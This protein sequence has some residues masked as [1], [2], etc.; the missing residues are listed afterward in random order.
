MRRLTRLSLCIYPLLYT[1]LCPSL[2]VSFGC[3]E[4]PQRSQQDQPII[5]GGL[6]TSAPQELDLSLFEGEETRDAESIIADSS[7]ADMEIIA[8]LEIIADI[9]LQDLSLSPDM[10]SLDHSLP[11]DPCVEGYEQGEQ[12]RC[13]DIDEC[14]L[15][16]QDQS[17]LC[18]ESDCINHNGGYHCFSDLDEDGVD[19]W[20]DNC[21][22]VI[23]P[24][25]GDLDRDGE[26][27]LCDA[28]RDGDLSYGDSDC[29]DLD[30]SLGARLEDAECDGALDRLSVRSHLSV[31]WRHSCAI[32]DDG[33]LTCWGGSP[34]IQEQEMN[35]YPALQVPTDLEGELIYDW[36]NLSAG[37]AYTCGIRLGGILT[38]WGD[39]RHQ[40]S[41]PPVN[42]NG[43][44]YRD[45]VKVSTGGASESFTC[46]LHADG[47]I[48]CWGADQHEQLTPPTDN[49]GGE[50]LELWVDLSSGYQ[51]SCG[52]LADGAIRCWGSD[53]FGQSTPPTENELGS[54]INEGAEG[55]EGPWVAVGAGYAHSCGLRA[56]GSIYC[57]GINSDQQSTPTNW[58]ELGNPRFWQGISVGGFHGCGIDAHRSAHCW[59]SNYTGQSRLPIE[60]FGDPYQDWVEVVA[61]RYHSC[62]IRESGEVTCWGWNDLGQSTPPADLRARKPPRQDNCRDLF[63]PSQS[64]MDNDGLGD[65]CDSD[66]DGDGL[67]S[68]IEEMWG[69]DPMNADSDSD[70]LSDGVE[71]GCDQ[72]ENDTWNCPDDAR[73]SSPNQAIDALAADSDQDQILDRDDNCPVID[74]FNQA[75]LDGDDLGDVCDQD[76]D[77]DGALDSEDCLPRDPTLSWRS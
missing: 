69:L 49:E 65:S 7:L 58:D 27:D 33:S 17:P 63:N 77:G 36:I 46:G 26:G 44:P 18:P 15:A 73:Q 41:S 66:P 10:E 72:Q 68:E 50:A 32:R 20:S 76:Q 47:T 16:E 6:D 9:G 57:W 45:W 29:D 67:L 51:H 42:A 21:L 19:D 11:C 37:Y 54:I 62:G 25:Q 43:E 34:R 53:Q 71:F 35:R 64:D 22:D 52:L 31:G 56:G 75:D 13:L 74:N 23:N 61:G 39:N 30:P 38:C 48:Q 60:L 28:D 5:D 59:G 12:C 4:R 14:D 40:Q 2:I 1:L 3:E 8:D 55:L 70:G 24:E